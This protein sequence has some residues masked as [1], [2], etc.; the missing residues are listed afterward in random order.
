MSNREQASVA[1]VDERAALRQRLWR[2]LLWKVPVILLLVGFAV[3]WEWRG[4]N[5]ESPVI[6]SRAVA[7]TGSWSGKVTY[8]SG[9]KHVESFFFQPEGKRLFGTAGF[10]GDR[11]GIEEGRLEGGEFSF[12]A[13]FP[14]AS[15]DGTH[16][17]KNYYWGKLT[18]SEILIR[19]QDDRGSAPVEWILAKSAGER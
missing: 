11:R 17:R 9:A 5:T 2:R 19:M 3:W 18:G 16:E 10:L 13:R 15:A 4:R 12:F 1:S 8:G 7:L 6:D 14:R